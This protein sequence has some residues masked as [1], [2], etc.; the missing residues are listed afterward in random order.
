M[1]QLKQTSLILANTRKFDARQTF[2]QLELGQYAEVLPSH[3]NRLLREA[4]VLVVDQKRFDQVTPVLLN[5]RPSH[6]GSA[7]TVSRHREV[8]VEGLRR[9]ALNRF[10]PGRKCFGFRSKITARNIEGQSIGQ[11]PARL[12]NR[13]LSSSKSLLAEHKLLK[14]VGSESQR[15]LSEVQQALEIPVLGLQ[16]L[17]LQKRALRPNHR[18][19]LLHLLATFPIKSRKITMYRDII[20]LPHSQGCGFRLK[21]SESA[22]LLK[23]TRS[24]SISKEDNPWDVTVPSI[25]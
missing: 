5:L 7:M 15:F 16:V 9:N 23:S 8:K 11:Q 25:N 12:F 18:L 4:A 20:A 14:S 24:R 22:L 10:E 21:Y 2:T 17:R 13:Q 6:I 1:I 19:E 3:L